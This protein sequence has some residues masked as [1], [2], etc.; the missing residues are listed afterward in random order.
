MA[1]IIPDTPHLFPLSRVSSSDQVSKSGHE[2]QQ[3]GL[4]QLS[5]RFELPLA[6]VMQLDGISAFKGEQIE[7]KTELGMFLKAVESGL[8][9]KGSILVCD[10]ATRLSRMEIDDSSHLLTGIIRKGVAVY[11]TN[12]D[13]LLKKGDRGLQVAL[14]VALIHFSEG[15]AASKQK[16]RFTY[17]HAR[18]MADRFLAKDAKAF[19]EGRAV[20]IKSMGSHPWWIDTSDGTV[21]AESYYF[22]IAREIIEKL[23]LGWGSYKVVDWL[24]A[25]YSPPTTNMTKA[26]ATKRDL[27]RWGQTMVTR[28][29]SGGANNG[30]SEALIGTRRLTFKESGESFVLD[31][32]YPAVATL[33]EVQRIQEQRRAKR[34]S[35]SS[36]HSSL[37]TGINILKCGYCDYAM[38]SFIH[39]N[40]LR[41]KC[42]GGAMNAA[43]CKSWG[44]NLSRLEDVCC[45][46]LVN[47]VWHPKEETVSDNDEV[48]ATANE[49]DITKARIIEAEEA[50][51]SGTTSISVIAPALEKLNQKQERLERELKQYVAN[52]DDSRMIVDDWDRWEDLS[53]AI[54]ELD[55]HELRSE[56]KELLRLSLTT[57]KCFRG[58]KERQQR[59][60][61]V[62]KDGTQYEVWNY[63]NKVVLSANT[64]NTANDYQAKAYHL[65]HWNDGP[66]Y[67]LEIEG[68][69]IDWDKIES[70]F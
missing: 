20:A 2:R 27:T 24:N 8:V 53:P 50:I 5:E 54:L 66:G 29:A 18:L 25:T 35:Q 64:L 56:V 40:K 15:Y 70:N 42:N 19:V 13:T 68:T 60:E 51:V 33:A 3:A 52:S 37:L 34:G 39:R 16:Q 31:S 61:V 46:L 23:L 48:L 9:A 12:D 41:C 57:I 11:F 36:K 30:T 47:H 28:F 59:F 62:L 49:L 58:E 26:K 7:D 22:P 4:T 6:P 32:Y 55:Q 63:T 21:K 69:D 10:D 14:L 67:T 38:T 45:R 1:G 65:Y 17:S 44:F 43:A